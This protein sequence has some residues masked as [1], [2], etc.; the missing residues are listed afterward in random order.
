MA[1]TAVF[2]AHPTHGGYARVV[3][4]MKE[5]KSIVEKQGLQPR[6]LRPVTGGD[7]GAVTLVTEYDSWAAFGK[8]SDKIQA[9][10][11]YQALMKRAAETPDSAL[12]SLSTNFYTTVD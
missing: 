7:Q 4:G 2:S 5:L 8:A 3:A 11:D 9:S 12:E 10:A 1:I 6:L